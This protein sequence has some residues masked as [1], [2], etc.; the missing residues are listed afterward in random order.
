MTTVLINLCLQAIDSMQ[1]GF[2][3]YP[4]FVVSRHY[5][6][7]LGRFASSDFAEAPDPGKELLRSCHRSN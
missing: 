2:I 7:L 3:R 1:N 5:G 6:P 4:V